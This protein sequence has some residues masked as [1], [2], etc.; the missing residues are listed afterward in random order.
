MGTS[1]VHGIGIA[2]DY[3]ILIFRDS[4]KKNAS[5]IGQFHGLDDYL[6]PVTDGRKVKSYVSN[7]FSLCN[8]YSWDVTTLNSTML[9]TFK[10]MKYLISFHTSSRR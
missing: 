1:I 6:V 9:V 2:Y 3:Y 4:M 10:W 5:F 7:N 8:I